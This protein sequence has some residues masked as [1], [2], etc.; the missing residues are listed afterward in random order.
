MNVYG[1]LS[2]RAAECA[3]LSKVINMRVSSLNPSSSST[4]YPKESLSSPLPSPPPIPRHLRR[5]TRSYRSYQ[6]PRIRKIRTSLSK[7]P[8]ERRCRKH[9][10][11]LAL[12]LRLHSPPSIPSIPTTALSATA[13]SSSSSS[14]SSWS[15]YTSPGSSSLVRWLETHVW[16]AKRFSMSE[17]YGVWKLPRHSFGR[18]AKAANAALATHCIV[19][20]ESHFT[21]LEIRG[22][23]ETILTVL[24]H[25]CDPLGAFF[26]DNAA[27]QGGK[28]CELLLYE[29]FPSGCIGPVEVMFCT[30]EEEE[31]A[32][33]N[34]PKNSFR[35]V[36]LESVCPPFFV[37]HLNK[38]IT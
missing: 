28:R 38:F 11:R 3:A 5:R 13:S 30:E 1:F 32:D 23:M 14:A 21:N 8:F 16:F 19:I 34:G 18:G 7:L 9:R 25:H 26:A 22:N 37:S 31:S 29:A 27:L 4:L 15:E 36:K 33:N 35:K 12:L 20:D 6:I 17:E 10:R 24:H 2:D